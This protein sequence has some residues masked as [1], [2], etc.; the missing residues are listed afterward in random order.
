MNN[1][2]T[3]IVM[4]GVPGAGKDYQIMNHKFFENLRSNVVSRDAIRF[5]ML[6]DGDDYF[7]NEKKVFNQFVREI[8]EGL[9]E[10]R[11]MVANATHINRGSRSKLIKAI[12]DCVNNKDYNI[13]FFVVETA[14]EVVL[15]Q[16]KKRVGLRCVPEGTITDMFNKFTMPSYKEDLRITDIYV[17]RGGKLMRKKGL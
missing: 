2:P 5:D 11:N 9:D 12:D 15:K 4:C 13:V 1:K 8:A 3:L 14:Y 16:N 17:F 7:K 10:G 6:K